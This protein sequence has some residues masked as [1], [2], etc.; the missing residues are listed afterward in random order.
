M[1]SA[2]VLASLCVALAGC[3]DL[4]PKYQRPAAPVPAAFPNGEAAARPIVG[5]RTFFSDP[6]LTAVIDGALA[7]NRD[8]RIA[9]ANAAAALAQYQVQRSNELPH[10]G[11]SLGAS[12]GQTPASVAGVPGG[13]PVTEHLYSANLGV[14][15]F[16]LDLFGRLR[17]LS[18]AAQ[19]SYFAS[20]E[21]REAAQISLLQAVAASFVQLAADRATLAVDRQTLAAGRQSLDLTAARLNAGVASGLDVSQARTIVE[22]AAS[23][24]A[25]MIAQVRQ[26]RD[27]LDLLVGAPVADALLPVDPA[28]P[29]AAPDRLP[30]GLPSAVLLRRPDV[31]QAED[32]LRGAN[33]NIGAARAAFFP[34]ISLTGSGGFASTALSGLFAGPAAAWS[35]TPAITQPL[36]DAG[37]NR[38]NLALAKAQRDAAVATYEKAIQSAFRDVADALAVRATIEAQVG[39]QTALVAASADALRLAQARYASGADTFLNVLIAERTLYAARQTL[40]ATQAARNLNLASL[41]AAFGGGLELGALATNAAGERTENRASSRSWLCW[42]GWPPTSI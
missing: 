30:A 37:F 22:Q 16:T 9:A 4:A 34:T 7:N 27:A 3:V 24:V 15:G 41:Y 31:V 26:D 35:F 5:W 2:S 39:A 33:A 10:L 38:G 42:T 18:R 20:Q 32:Q 8:L 28:T 17:N 12:F 40:I 36:F 21:G 19:D 25:R 14:S 11:A 29:I 6:K 23:D 1:R 13:S